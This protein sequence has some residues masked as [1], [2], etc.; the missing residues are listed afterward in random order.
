M[1]PRD[2]WLKAISDVL[3]GI[4]REKGLEFSQSL[5]VAEK[6]PQAELGDLAFPMFSFSKTLRQG[7]PQIA[8]LVASTLKGPGTATAAG[9][10]VNVR[11][12]RK[13]F[14][15]RVITQVLAAGEKYGQS[16]SY[17]GQKVLVEFSS[18]NTNKPLHL[19]HLRNN[20]L[21]ESTS[22]ILRAN[23]A[24]VKKVNLFNDRGIHI[25]KSMVA[26]QKWA[27]GGTP[28]ST[29]MKSDHFVADLYV[30]FQ[31]ELKLQIKALKAADPSLEPKNDDDLWAQT[32]IGAQAAQMLRD[33]ELGEATVKALWTT[34]NQW[35]VQGI[36]ETYRKTGITFDWIQFEHQTYLFGKDEVLKGLESGV[37]Y[38]RPDGAVC[39][40][41]P[42]KENNQADSNAV[43]VVLRSDGTSIYL[44]QDIGTAVRRN[45]EWPFDQAVYVVANEQDYH[46]KVLFYILG[47]LGMP[48]AS[49]LFH[50]SYGLVNLPTGWMKTREGTVVDADDLLDELARLSAEE[51]KSK[52][53]E[54]EVEDVTGT[55]YSIAL[56][57]LSYYLLQVTPSKD[58]IFNTEESLSFNGNTGPYLQYMGA[59]ISSILAKYELG[60]KPGTFDASLLS[61]DGDWELVRLIEEFPTVV[62]QAG[63]DK[64]PALVA[65]FLYEIAKSFSRYYHDNP[66]LN[67][68]NP[69]LSASRIALSQG[70]LHVLK[71]GFYLLNIPF[72]K[73]M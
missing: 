45:A 17:Q 66:V 62:M 4:Y 34:M 55:S 14:T 60:E 71:N 26:Y 10:Y 13:D 70:V 3:E 43:K 33:W 64:N 36:M 1:E 72:L 59:R 54:A 9:P 27:S 11:F 73:S 32:E 53:R 38:K 5:V 30:K 40:E 58:M 37:F 63:R 7:P 20:A 6:P 23:G 56:G 15:Q 29:G 8:V 69:D 49:K 68:E 48:W 35:A 65:V 21:G 19:G 22:R 39:V 16:D 28:E 18:P 47:K 12:D 44:T 24:E 46:F 41:L 25:C 61:S 31:N 50:L 57:A 2:I 67:N 52:G 51:I 42:W